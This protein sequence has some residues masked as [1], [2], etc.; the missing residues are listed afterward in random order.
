VAPG[1]YTAGLL[2]RPSSV[3][4]LTGQLDWVRWS[5]VGSALVSPDDRP[6]TGEF[7]L[8]DALDGRLGLE[9]RPDYGES[10]LWNRVVLRFGLHYR[11]RGL[12][13]YT[14]SDPVEQARFGGGS[15]RWEWSYGLA[16]GPLEITWV[17]RKPSTVW[18]IGVRQFF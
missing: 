3:V 11:S 13:E 12:L 4:W 10:P 15:H 8:D 14:G 6:A 9:V 1:R 16:F 7:V 5:E 17:R 2:F 18:V